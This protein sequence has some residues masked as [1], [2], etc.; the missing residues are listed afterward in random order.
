MKYI[1]ALLLI[2]SC[3]FGQ[4]TTPNLGLGLLPHK[5]T[6]WDTQTNINWNLVDAGTIIK[7]PLADQVIGGGHLLT[8]LGGFVGPLTIPAQTQ[9]AP[10]FFDSSGLLVSDATRLDCT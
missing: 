2:S 4:S 9:G 7:N 1:I 8:N 6:N 10:A 3:V 5:A